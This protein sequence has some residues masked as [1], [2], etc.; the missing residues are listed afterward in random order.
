MRKWA[1]GDDPN[2]LQ[3]RRDVRGAAC[4]AL[5]QK[6]VTEMSISTRG[7]RAGSTPLRRTQKCGREKALNHK[8]AAKQSHTNLFYLCNGRAVTRKS[9]GVFRKTALEYL[10]SIPRAMSEK[11]RLSFPVRS[12]E[13]L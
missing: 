12:L 7:G 13:R 5:V 4:D 10:T 9:C 8:R 3:T 11:V 6:V 1:N 2:E